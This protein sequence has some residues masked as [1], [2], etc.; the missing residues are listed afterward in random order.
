MSSEDEKFHLGEYLHEVGEE[1][2]RIA[3]PH[4]K[5]LFESTGLVLVVIVALS[6]LV[7]LSDK[8][9]VSVLSALPK[10]LG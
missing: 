3:W 5:E 7:A 2:K 9:L 4:R 1:Y 8:I 6:L 10:L